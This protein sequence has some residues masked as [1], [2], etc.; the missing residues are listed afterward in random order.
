MLYLATQFASLLVSDAHLLVNGKWLLEKDGRVGK[1]MKKVIRGKI[2]E[3]NSLGI[4][5][6]LDFWCPFP[7]AVLFLWEAYCDLYKI[8]LLDGL[9]HV[10]CHWM[11]VHCVQQVG[12]PPRI[13]YAPVCLQLLS[14]VSRGR[15]TRSIRLINYLKA[16]TRKTLINSLWWRSRPGLPH[17]AKVDCLSITGKR[18]SQSSTSVK[19]CFEVSQRVSERASL[20]HEFHKL[21]SKAN[22]LRQLLKAP[23][24]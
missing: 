3:D 7:L 8:V 18:L 13:P 22:L 24:N 15:H 12:W 5:L 20:R 9:E 16:F 2:F 23:R 1:R 14:R 19:S 6:K 10:V 21:T 17:S 11:R 4:I